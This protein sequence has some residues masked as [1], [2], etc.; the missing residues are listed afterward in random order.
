M[1][2]NTA[3]AKPNVWYPARPWGFRLLRSF[4]LVYLG[5]MGILYFIQ[6]SIIFPGAQTQG[7]AFAVV[8]PPTGTELVHL[9]SVSGEQIVALFGPALD[10]DGRP[11]PDAAHRPSLIYFYG[12]GMCL[13]DTLYDIDR[14]RRLGLNVLAPDYV[15][16][17]MSSGRPS[18]R[19]CY[20][21]ADACYDYLIA[22][23]DIDESKVVAG[24]WSLGGAVAID[25]AARRPI[26]RLA[27]FSSFTSMRDMARRSFPFLPVSLLLRHRFESDRK[28][29]EV[30]CP[31]LI[32]HGQADTLVPAGMSDRLAS[33]ART[34]VTRL[35]I[36]GADHNDFFATG[37]SNIFEALE[38][39]LDPLSRAAE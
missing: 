39:F 9:K 14:F 16:Y 22:R 17:G 37:G 2:A 1:A 10:A 24:G 7:Q 8:Y 20:E 3:A 4:V 6:T 26:A 11:H 33:V 21:T 23:K 12:N 13:R 29:P 35:N 32:G 34:E 25:L 36:E 38:Q 28:L 27:I 30:R 31:I 15:G 18:E 19:G 5:V